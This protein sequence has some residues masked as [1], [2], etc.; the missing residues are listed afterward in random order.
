[1]WP[2]GGIGERDSTGALS[3]VENIPPVRNQLAESLQPWKA[4][5]DLELRM[6]LNWILCSFDVERA[7]DKLWCGEQQQS[8]G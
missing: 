4:L 2:L 7:G 8:K 1:M 6:S 3:V 5:G